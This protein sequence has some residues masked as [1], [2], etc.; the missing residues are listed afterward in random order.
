ML[1]NSVTG[2]DLDRLA[3]KIND[4]PKYVLQAKITVYIPLNTTDFDFLY[5]CFIESRDNS[6]YIEEGGFMYTHK[7]TRDL[8]RDELEFKFD[9][10]DIDV[11]LRVMEDNP[12][13]S[14]STLFWEI[15]NKMK[16]EREKI[17]N[18]LLNR[19]DRNN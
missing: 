12:N 5:N 15:M 16:I 14:L 6:Y 4:S 9:M 17:N 19:Y 3:G 1:L 2:K 13:P 8:F 18:E 7:I 11:C 10:G